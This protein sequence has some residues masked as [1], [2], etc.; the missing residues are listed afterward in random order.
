MRGD[1]MAQEVS[2]ILFFVTDLTKY[3]IHNIK[4]TKT[5]QNAVS[6]H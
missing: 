5:E 6:I 1:D 4:T 2:I 3:E